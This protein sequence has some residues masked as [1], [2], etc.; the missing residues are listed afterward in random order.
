MVK[1]A[2]STEGGDAPRGQGAT[3]E[4]IGP[5]LGNNILAGVNL[6]SSFGQAGVVSLGL[7]FGLALVISL[8]G[9]ISCAAKGKRIERGS[10]DM[11]EQKLVTLAEQLGRI[12][13]TVQ[14]KA[15]GSFDRRALN[16]PW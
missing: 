16:S 9:V 12:V 7:V 4:N 10:A 6:L 8:V 5:Y 13:G 1:V 15:E 2:A 11:V 3:T 14:T